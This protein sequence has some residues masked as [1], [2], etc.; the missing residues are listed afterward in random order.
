LAAVLEKGR[1]WISNSTYRECSAKK[2]KVGADGPANAIHGVL[3]L[4][5]RTVDPLMQLP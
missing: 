5:H 3:G 2:A 1:S 4:G